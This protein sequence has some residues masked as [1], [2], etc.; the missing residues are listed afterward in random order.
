MTGLPSYFLSFRLPISL[1]LVLLLFSCVKNKAENKGQNVSVFSDIDSV[2]LDPSL[3]NVVV[4]VPIQTANK[5]WFG[6]GNDNNQQAENLALEKKIFNLKSVSTGYVSGYDN[7]MVFA[8]VIVN[9]RIYFLDARGNLKAWNL[10][11]YKKIWQTK[12]I[13]KWTLK[14][15]TNGKISYFNNSIFAITGSN[16]VLK[17]NSLDGQII[18]SKQI[19]AIPASAPISDGNQ[20]FVITNDNKTYALSDKDGN[21]NWVHSG[22]LRSTAILG[23]ANPVVYQ[24]YLVASYSSGELYVL[25]KKSGETFWSYD[26]NLSK[27]IDSD[28]ILNDI[29]ATPIIKNDVV[30]A[31]GNGG[32]MMAIAIRTGQV[33]WQKELASISDFWIAGDFIYLINSQNQLL[34]LSKSSGGIKWFLK[35][36]KYVKEKKPDKKI[37]YNGLIMAGDNLIVTN[38][39]RQLLLIS[40]VNGNII[41]SKRL[42]QKAYHSP[43]VVDRKLYLHTIGR[44]D[45]KLLIF[46]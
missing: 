29:D 43:I 26:L 45:S 28:F 18:W 36:P 42:D 17:V 30:Y 9:N 41:Q 11:N 12:L 40:A 4:R 16:L 35:L 25:E 21:I 10:N 3:K 5:S 31:I 27:A 44:F 22:V 24:N 1:I 8:P 13:K 15:F 19:G 23:T 20:V 37:F 34:C 32:L 14:K 39:N 38:S 2:T 6:S 33:L 7:R 46:N